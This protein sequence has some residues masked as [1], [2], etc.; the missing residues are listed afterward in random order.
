MLFNG[1]TTK[2]H[3]LWFLAS[4]ISQNNW[5]IRL[6]QK[7]VGKIAIT[8]R[9]ET[10]LNT[11]LCFR[12][13]NVFGKRDKNSCS[14][15]AIISLLMVSIVEILLS[16]LHASTNRIFALWGQRIFHWLWLCGQ[17]LFSLLGLPPSFLASHIFA[18]RRSC[19]WLTEEKRETAHSLTQFW[20]EI[21]TNQK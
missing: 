3:V 14:A 21:K 10:T 13:V 17:S 20:N 8:S 15:S 5:K 1:A 4:F 9:P 11:V 7:P 19:V 12:S 18:A 16:T 2:I 6:F